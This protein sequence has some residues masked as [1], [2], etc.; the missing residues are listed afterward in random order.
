MKRKLA[1]ILAAGML[2]A[3]LAGCG[4]VHVTKSDVKVTH[5]GSRS[6]IYFRNGYKPGEVEITKNDDGSYD[7]LIR[8]VPPTDFYSN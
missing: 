2:V 4:D 6:Y 3:T 1:G 7:I 8:G 5:D